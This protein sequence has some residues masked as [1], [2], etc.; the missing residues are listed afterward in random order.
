MTGHGH[1]AGTCG[2]IDSMAPLARALALSGVLAGLTLA[3]AGP[4]LADAETKC[5]RDAA[6]HLICVK[7]EREKPERCTLTCRKDS[8]GRTVC[9]ERC[10]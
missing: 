7:V 10:R 3:S 4:V 8:G 2:T 1:L 6:G 5:K 9:R